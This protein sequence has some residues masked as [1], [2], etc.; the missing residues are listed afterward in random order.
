[1]TSPTQTLAQIAI[2]VPAA[3][4]VFLRHGLDF[5]CH[6]QRS[7]AE[8][9]REKGIDPEQVTHELEAA[10]VPDA[11]AT[12]WKDRPL[13]ELVDF[14]LA[15]YH[16]PLRG[17][18]ATLIELASKVERVH[19]DKPSCPHGLAAHLAQVLEALESHLGKEEQILFPMIRDGSAAMALMP[20]KVMM[21]EHED[22]GQ[23]LRRTRELTADL[24]APPEACT[25]WRALYAGL[26]RLEAELMQHIHLENNLLFPRAVNGDGA[27]GPQP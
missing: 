8:A 27:P 5:C 12:S 11:G 10:T 19:E 4:G 16:A 13:D 14:I 6:G 24:V 15:R 7:L 26:T 9:C 25:T 3:P 1:M 20:V 22:H 18:V 23:N 2:D 21:Q 17:D